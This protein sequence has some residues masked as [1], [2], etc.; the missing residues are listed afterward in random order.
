M[1]LGPDTGPA[2][3]T[4]KI[5]AAVTNFTAEQLIGNEKLDDATLNV[6]VDPSGLRASGQGMMFG[7]PV[8]IDMDETDRTSLPKLRLS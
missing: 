7:V 2:D 3:T 1:K 8:A 5:N 6:S 4:L